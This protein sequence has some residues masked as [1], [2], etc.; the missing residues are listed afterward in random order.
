LFNARAL[1]QFDNLPRS[2]VT[3]S[4]KDMTLKQLIERSQALIRQSQELKREHEKLL[5]E[6][7]D[8]QERTQTDE[9]QTD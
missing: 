4:P 7:E 1:P 2:L 5:R 6:L 3:D 9:R 8:L